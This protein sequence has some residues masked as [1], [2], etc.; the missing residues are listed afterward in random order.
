MARSC[1]ADAAV[2]PVA[3]RRLSRAEQ[4]PAS[5]R[6]R[7]LRRAILTYRWRAGVFTRSTRPEDERTAR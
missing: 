3:P 7:T 4:P 6:A 1:R 5:G 2:P